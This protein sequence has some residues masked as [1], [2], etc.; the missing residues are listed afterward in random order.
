MPTIFFSLIGLLSTIPL[1]FL[2]Y[3]G[4]NS[5]YVHVGS[6]LMALGLLFYARVSIAMFFGMAIFC[7]LVL[8]LNKWLGQSIEM[9]YALFNFILFAL[10]WVGQFIEHKIEGKK[11]SFFKD[12]Q[13]LLIGPA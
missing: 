5:T 7:Y 4:D 10:A 8:F 3:H 6:L 1:S 2:G 9:N 11:P 12:L 13:F